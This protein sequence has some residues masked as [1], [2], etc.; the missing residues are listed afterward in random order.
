M[1][2]TFRAMNLFD[3]LIITKKSTSHDALRIVL[4]DFSVRKSLMAIS[5]T[6]KRI[7]SM[8]T[9]KQRL[10]L[11]VFLNSNISLRIAYTIL[12]YRILYI[13]IRV[14]NIVRNEVI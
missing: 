4:V 5:E 10:W 12:T 1:I 11:F 8:L 3:F 13:I 2:L 7:H 6:R 14:Q 9:K